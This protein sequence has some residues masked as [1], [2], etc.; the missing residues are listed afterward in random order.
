MLPIGGGVRSGSVP[1]RTEQSRRAT[2]DLSRRVA[3]ITYAHDLP[4][5][6]SPAAAKAVPAVLTDQGGAK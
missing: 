1:G 6:P 5:L 3:A 4:G 2:V